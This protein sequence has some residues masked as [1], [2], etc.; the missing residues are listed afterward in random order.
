MVCNPLQDWHSKI[1]VAFRG[2]TSTNLSGL[3]TT[4]AVSEFIL[5]FSALVFLGFGE[6]VET[7]FKKLN[8]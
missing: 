6:R 1:Q 7:I 5:Q 8:K 4:Q 3:R 2:S